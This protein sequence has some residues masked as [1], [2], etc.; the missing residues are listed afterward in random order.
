LISGVFEEV[1]AAAA[2]A[3]VAAYALAPGAVDFG[4]TPAPV[5][6]FDLSTPFA[7]P[8]KPISYFWTKNVF[9]FENFRKNPIIQF[10]SVYLSHVMQATHEYLLSPSLI[11]SIYLLCNTLK[12]DFHCLLWK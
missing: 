10:N 4:L 1:A 7:V 11:S 9:L 3:D 12:W 8:F 6:G 2:P 5:P